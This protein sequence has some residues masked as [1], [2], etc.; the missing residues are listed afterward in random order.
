MVILFKFIRSILVYTIYTIIFLSK[1]MLLVFA[2]KFIRSILVYMVIFFG[3][4][5]V[6]NFSL[7]LYGEF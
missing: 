2:F 4:N 1:E 3:G 7:S 5:A 6:G